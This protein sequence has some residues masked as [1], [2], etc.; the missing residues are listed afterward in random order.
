MLAL[1]PYTSCHS[2][3]DLQRTFLSLFLRRVPRLARAAAV[4]PPSPS[5][6]P[7]ADVLPV[8]LPLVVIPS[9]G[10]PPPPSLAPS[11]SPS[12]APLP[13]V[14]RALTRRTY[15]AVAAG[16]RWGGCESGTGRP[17]MLRRRCVSVRWNTLQHISSMHTVVLSSFYTS[18]W[19]AINAV[20]KCKNVIR[21]QA[22]CALG[23]RG[24]GLKA[25]TTWYD[26]LILHVGA[27]S[28]LDRSNGHKFNE[29]PL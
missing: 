4:A 17:M 28:I 10:S 19:R 15:V 26:Y 23:V 11:P 16:N 22:G 6:I 8:P 18:G 5:P 27:P 7:S 29:S 24:S 13:T 12:L 20:V 1:P 3:E 25:E 14:R 2:S 21:L 9:I